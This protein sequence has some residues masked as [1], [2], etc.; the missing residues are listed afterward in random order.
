MI[1]LE[2]RNTTTV[3]QKVTWTNVIGDLNGEKIVEKFYEKEWKKINQKEF[4]MEE[5]AT[6]KG[7]KPYVKWKGY[8]NSYN[9]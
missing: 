5:V 2:Y 6:R 1:I 4:K 9:S 7:D 8:D 3:L